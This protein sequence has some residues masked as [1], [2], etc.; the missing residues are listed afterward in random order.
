MWIADATTH[1]NLLLFQRCPL[2]CSKGNWL[3]YSFRFQIR[4]RLRV[5]LGLRSLGEWRQ[6]WGLWLNTRSR[7]ARQNCFLGRGCWRSDVCRE[8]LD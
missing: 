1:R 3:S 8:A 7:L 5:R 4:L 2:L 6:G